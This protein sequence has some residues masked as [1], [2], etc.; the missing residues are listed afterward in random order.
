[1]YKALEP[2]IDDARNSDQIDPKVSWTLAGRSENKLIYEP[3]DLNLKE[4]HE[5]REALLKQFPTKK[6][7]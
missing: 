5:K 6:E 4:T 1:L 2:R 3:G 7:A